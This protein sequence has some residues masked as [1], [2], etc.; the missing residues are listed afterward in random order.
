MAAA[1]NGAAYKLTGLNFSA[2]GSMSAV[3]QVIQAALSAAGIPATIAF[4]TVENSNFLPSNAGTTGFSRFVLTGAYGAG[5]TIGLASAPASGTDIVGLLGLGSP[6]VVAQG[7]S[8]VVSA[9]TMLANGDYALWTSGPV[10]QTIILGDDSPTRKYDVGFG[11]GYHPFRP[12]FYATFWPATNQVHIRAVGSNNLTSEVEDIAYRLSVSI[13][14]RDPAVVLTSDLSANPANRTSANPQPRQHWAITSWTREFWLGR[15]PPSQVNI[16]N[17]LA[18]LTATRF[19]PNYDTS[20]PPI[21]EATIAS[22]YA[23]WTKA[24]KDIGDAGLWDP[25]MGD[26]GQRPEIGPYPTWHVLW[27]YSGDWR[28][29][30]VAL[31]QSDLAAAWNLELRESVA[32]KRLSRSDAAGSSTGYGRT[33]SVVDH[34]TLLTKE[35]GYAYTTAPDAPAF[36][37]PYNQKQPWEADDA[38][39]PSPFYI[40]YVLTGDPWDLQEMY[41]WAGFT[42]LMTR[43]ARANIA[44]TDRTS[45][46]PTGA[47]GGVDGQWM[48]APAWTGRNRAETAFIAPDGDPEKFYFTYMTNDMLAGW[49]GGVGITGTI[50]D[51]APMK[52]W[53]AA[54]GNPF[55]TVPG[56]SPLGNFA[57]DG[58]G[59]DLGFPGIFKPGTVSGGFSPWNSLVLSICARQDQRAWVCRAAVGEVRFEAPRRHGQPDQISS[60][61]YFIFCAD[62]LHRSAGW[63][64]PELERLCLYLRYTLPVHDGPAIGLQLPAKR[65]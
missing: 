35:F 45:R 59:K 22:E 61:S 8:Q 52:I 33:I 6:A 47:Y 42:A 18:Y 31:G 58:N 24:G 63:L 5:A 28:L 55:S 54:L 19:L 64:D 12:H 4:Q 56:V 34:A 29:R 48:R 27:V 37:G 46:G 65:Q 25:G 17:N 43:G 13:G 49:E 53:A 7:S 21:P 38:H 62:L 40:N 50:Y 30:A 32:G 10:A 51:G 9:R 2:A 20:L 1:I 44:S 15:T 3:S 36:V 57:N 23:A 26:A 41:L 16:D 11:D 14:Q 39:Q 60:A